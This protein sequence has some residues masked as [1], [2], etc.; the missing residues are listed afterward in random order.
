MRED[1]MNSRPLAT[2]SPVVASPRPL[3]EVTMPVPSLHFGCESAV[4]RRV[5]TPRFTSKF[6]AIARPT[7]IS[8]AT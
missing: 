4:M 2:V 6:L 8:G 1:A 7:R 3:L 5:S